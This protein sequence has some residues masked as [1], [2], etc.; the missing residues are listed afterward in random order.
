LHTIAQ[1]KAL[2]EYSDLR[3]GNI[4]IELNNHLEGGVTEAYQ[5]LP[6]FQVKKHGNIEFELN[7][8]IQP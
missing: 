2:I 1:V 6:P 3:C 4:I 8:K 7:Q 5:G